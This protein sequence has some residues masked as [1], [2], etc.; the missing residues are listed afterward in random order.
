M[1]AYWQ[2]SGFGWLDL[3]SISLLVIADKF[4]H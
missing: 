2:E 4:V 1:E 3:L